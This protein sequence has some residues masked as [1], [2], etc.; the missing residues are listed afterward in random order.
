MGCIMAGTRLNSPPTGFESRN[1][2]KLLMDRTVAK[3]SLIL[4]MEAIVI[5]IT[6][7]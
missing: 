4:S 2:T 1:P 5:T 7:P 6:I 3:P